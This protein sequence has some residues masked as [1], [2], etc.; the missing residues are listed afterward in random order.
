MSTADDWATDPNDVDIYN[1]LQHCLAEVGTW[2]WSTCVEF[3]TPHITIG[4]QTWSSRRTRALNSGAGT[5]YGYSRRQA[6]QMASTLRAELLAHASRS[7]S[8]LRRSAV[9]F[10]LPVDGHQPG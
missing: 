4:H 2:P 5:A 6:R 3:N 1:H 9:E 10:G 7:G 8:Y